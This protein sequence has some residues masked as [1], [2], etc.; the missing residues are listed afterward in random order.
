MADRSAER[1]EHPRIESSVS[2]HIFCHTVGE[3]VVLTTHN[4]SCSG[5]QCHISHF[6]SPFTRLKLTLVLTLN[7]GKSGPRHRALD[8]EGVVVRTYP[9]QEEPGRDDYQ[10]GVFFSEL[11]EEAREKIAEYVVEH[12]ADTVAPAEE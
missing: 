2:G 11:S 9:E 5:M 10:I 3:K 8:I 1:R 7:D 4:I 6:I 12:D